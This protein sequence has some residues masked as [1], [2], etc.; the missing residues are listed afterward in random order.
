MV[1]LNFPKTE[2]VFAEQTHLFFHLRPARLPFSVWKGEETETRRM[3][4]G[5]KINFGGGAH[6]WYRNRISVH[7]LVP[8]SLTAGGGLVQTVKDSDIR[9]DMISFS[10]VMCCYAYFFDK[11]PTLRLS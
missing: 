1:S 11:N 6:P 7:C 8:P 2:H 3:C 9:I 4:V 10:I 5:F